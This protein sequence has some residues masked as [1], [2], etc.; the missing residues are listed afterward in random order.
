MTDANN[1][2]WDIGSSI[3]SLLDI[4]SLGF[5]DHSSLD[6]LDPSWLEYPNE[7]TILPFGEYCLFSLDI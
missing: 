4:F 2:E 1:F 3:F 6:S 7:E 5:L